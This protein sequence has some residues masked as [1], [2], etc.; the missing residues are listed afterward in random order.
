MTA[1]VVASAAC[2]V[3][4]A[5]PPAATPL[6]V[7]LGLLVLNGT[8]R[9]VGLTA[10]NTVAFADVTPGRMTSANTLMSTVQELR[11][12]LGVAVGDGPPGVRAPTRRSSARAGRLRH[13]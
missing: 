3:A 1:V 11:A 7:L 5:V 13:A 6:P 2:L 8:F 9:S 4:T 10:Y 12:G